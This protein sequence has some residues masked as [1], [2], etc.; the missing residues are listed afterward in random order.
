MQRRK[1]L[2]LF[3]AGLT[4][5]AAGVALAD[6]HGHGH[7]EDDDEHGHGN[8]QGHGNGHN[9]H[10]DVHDYRYSDRDR[11][12]IREW[13]RTHQNNLPPGSP[14]VTRSLPAWNGS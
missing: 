7:D 12:Q 6:D 8:G 13:Y 5:C 4:G 3:T 2:Y 11:G 9:K 14:S 10:A 1:W